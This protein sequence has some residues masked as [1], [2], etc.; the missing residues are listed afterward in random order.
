M[1]RREQQIMHSHHH[2][3]QAHMHA[4]TRAQWSSQC[5]RTHTRNTC[6]THALSTST[7]AC[8]HAR[9][10]NKTHTH[11]PC[12]HTCSTNEYE[13]WVV[14]WGA[15]LSMSSEVGL[16]LGQGLGSGLWVGGIGRRP[17]NPPQH[18]QC[19]CCQGVLNPENP[20]L[21]SSKY[22]GRESLAWSGQCRRTHPQ[23]RGLLRFRPKHS[24]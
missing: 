17:L 24:N 9:T 4:C 21:K 23:S 2:H 13:L 19:T 11:T 12:T 22:R 16:G 20:Y 6:K 8:M 3:K 14:A 18:V 15:C 5:P 1:Y 7:H 10:T